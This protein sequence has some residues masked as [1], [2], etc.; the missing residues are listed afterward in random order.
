MVQVLSDE[1]GLEKEVVFEAL[2]IALAAAARKGYKV[3]VEIRVHIDRRSGDFDTFRRW[4]VIPDTE[5]EIESPGRQVTESQAKQNGSEVEVGEFIEEQIP[6]A[7]IGRISA[8]TAKQVIMQ[9]VRE[10]ERAQIVAEFSPKIGTMVF[11]QVKRVERGDLIVDIDG[12]EA[13]LY[14]S[15]S[16]PREGMKMGDRLR[17]ILKDVRADARGPALILDRTAP[18]LLVQLFKLEVPESREGLVSIIG[19]ARDPGSRAKIAVHS[20]DPKVDPI[21]ACV[22]LRGARVQAV[23]KEI[24]GERVDIVRWAANPVQFV[25]NALAPATVQAMDVLEESQTM[26]VVVDDD[27]QLSQ[28]IGKHGQNVRLATELTGWTL[29]IMTKFDAEEQASVVAREK[30]ER[31]MKVL[32]VG[33]NAAEILV[34]EGYS[35]LDDI[36]FASRESLLHIREFED[37]ETLVDEIVDRAQNEMLLLAIARAETPDDQSPQDDLLTMDGM[38]SDTAWLLARNGIYTMEDLAGCDLDDLNTMGIQEA[39]AGNLIMTA[40]KPWFEEQ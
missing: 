22:G 6:S 29:N 9:K 2:E 19:A 8:Q 36:V 17:A 10:A 24:A 31:L 28:A 4:E 39:R 30:V 5:E 21:G 11:G 32:D 7:S 18:E 34:Q 23:S 27:S 40:R 1:K 15:L 3:D 12:V 20:D 26:N 35:T 37:K 38:D 13:I 16:I 33:E 14:R 25:I